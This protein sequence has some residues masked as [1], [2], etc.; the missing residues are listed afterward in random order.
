MQTADLISCLLRYKC[1]QLPL[2]PLVPFHSPHV[3]TGSQSWSLSLPHLASHTHSCKFILNLETHFPMG[4]CLHEKIL[5]SFLFLAT[6][7]KNVIGFVHL[8]SLTPTPRLSHLHFSSLNIQLEMKKADSVSYIDFITLRQVIICILHMPDYVF[9]AFL[10]RAS[11]KKN[12]SLYQL[13]ISSYYV[14]QSLVVEIIS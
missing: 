8:L 1:L 6:I 9:C 14:T 5:M 11:K 3:Y 7:S 4:N 10:K 13:A 2:L 12:I